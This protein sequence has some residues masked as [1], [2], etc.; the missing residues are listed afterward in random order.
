MHPWKAASWAGVSWKPGHLRVLLGRPRAKQFC[1]GS[2]PWS[3]GSCIFTGG[4][5]VSAGLLPTPF[6]RG[7]KMFLKYPLKSL[8]S[9]DS[10]TVWG[11]PETGGQIRGPESRRCSEWPQC[12]ASSQG[13]EP[14]AEGQGVSASALGTSG[15]G[16][17]LLLEGPSQDCQ[18]KSLFFQGVLTGSC[19][20]NGPLLSSPLIF[21]GSIFIP[22]AELSE[23]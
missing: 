19:S 4:I 1:N 14:I 12:N 5:E 8:S 15:A 21:W 7:L 16:S 23:T 2:G 10:R 13:F 3:L 6:Q 11:Q 20:F 9:K 18:V 22:S 17:F